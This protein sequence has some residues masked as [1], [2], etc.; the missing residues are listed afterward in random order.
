MMILDRPTGLDDDDDDDD[1][2]GDDDLRQANR[3]R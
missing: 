2:D 3:S 1:D